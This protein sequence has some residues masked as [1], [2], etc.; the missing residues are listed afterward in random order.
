MQAYDIYIVDAYLDEETQ[1]TEN[2]F[3]FDF[4]VDPN[5]SESTDA[6]RFSL[7]LQPVTL[8]LEDVISESFRMYPNPLTDGHLTI[9]LPQQIQGE[10]NVKIH[11]VLG[12]LCS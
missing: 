9:D 5:I 4:N 8:G 10:F 6:N 1:I 2:G 3:V 11:N 7:K 12:E